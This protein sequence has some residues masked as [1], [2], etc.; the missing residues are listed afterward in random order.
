MRDHNLSEDITASEALCIV[1]FRTPRQA[2]A[3]AFAEGCRVRGLSKSED[4]PERMH[5]EEDTSFVFGS[6]IKHP[7][8]LVLGYYCVHTSPE[9]LERAEA[10][11]LRIGAARRNQGRSSRAL[12]HLVSFPGK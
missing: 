9:A 10:E 11:I 3:A 12:E 2:Y 8:P 4:A 6:A 7:H 5:A 1:Q